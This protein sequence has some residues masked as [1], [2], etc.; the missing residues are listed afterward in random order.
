MKILLIFKGPRSHY[1]PSFYLFPCFAFY[2]IV[3][4]R[5]LW[6][7][8]YDHLSGQQDHTIMETTFI[9]HGT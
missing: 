7:W 3:L 4:L 1:P 5:K 2:I 8:F 9:V 6:L